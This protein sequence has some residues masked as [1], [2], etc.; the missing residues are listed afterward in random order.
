M[1]LASWMVSSHKLE[2]CFCADLGN[3]LVHCIAK[4]QGQLL[5]LRASS[6]STG[7]ATELLNCISLTHSRDQIIP[8]CPKLELRSSEH[9][10]NYV[11]HGVVLVVQVDKVSIAASSCALS[12]SWM[13]Q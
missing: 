9:W 5:N 4:Q 13:K 1:F 2:F 8:C 12:H 3:S 6:A 11:K 7:K 10:C